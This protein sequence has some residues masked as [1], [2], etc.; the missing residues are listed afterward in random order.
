MSG[1]LRIAIRNCV[2]LFS[3]QLFLAALNL[4]INAMSG[5]TMFWAIFP[6]LG[7]AIPQVIQIGQALV[8]GPDSTLRVQGQEMRKPSA[9]RFAD[10]VRAYQEELE[11]RA[12]LIESNARA[13]RL[14][15]LARQFEE[16]AEKVE[17]ME[18]QVALLQSDALLQNDRRMALDALRDLD[19]RIARESD[20]NVRRS[21]EQTV[22]ARRTQLEAL[23]TLSA[24]T[25]HAEAHLE[26]TV[27]SLGAIYTQA[28]TNLSSN[29]ASDYQRLAADVDERVRVL[30]D[31]LAAIEEV[32]LHDR[33]DR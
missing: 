25:R 26:A 5:S 8:S 30:Q 23:D 17:R 29:N 13:E 21:L 27:A 1:P 18:E 2:P 32:R 6:I 10:Q 28:L 24:T 3:V 20:A 15:S 33:R 7:M 16:W 22:A 11:H 12:A 4:V 19:A 14:S 31:E 9:H